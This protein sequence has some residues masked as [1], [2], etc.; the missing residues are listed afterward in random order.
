MGSAQTRPRRKAGKGR[1]AP[2]SAGQDNPWALCQQAFAAY[3]HGRHSRPLRY[4]TI[5]LTT[6]P[7]RC[8][9]AVFL[10][11]QDGLLAKKDEQLPL[12]R[13][14][15]GTLQYIYFVEDFVFVVPVGTEEVVVSD[16][17]CQV[18]AGAV[19]VIK[20]VCMAVR[21][22]IGAVEPF[23]HLFKRAVF[24]RNS[25]IV[26]KADNL[27]DFKH[28]AFAKLLR[29]F[30]CGKWISA[31]A[32]GDKL[33]V[34][35]QFCESSECHAHG[36]DAGADTAVA[37][38]LVADNGAC[39]R[40]HDEPDIGFD[41][42]YFDVGFVSGKYIPFFVGVKVNKG[43]DTDGGGLAVVGDLLMGNADVVQVFECL[44]SFA[45][46]KAEVDMEC[47]AQG[48]DMCVIPAE[49]EGGS[50]LGQGV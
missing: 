2:F 49:F 5:L 4:S 23:D 30:H 43:F 47:E 14:V 37:G 18:I 11:V 29:E 22:F 13:H 40:V 1:S 50:V 31:V 7:L 36:K 21:G 26:G 10:Q 8:Q 20:A 9:T 39:C 3:P 24:R 25:V 19:N 48:H 42:A 28:E 6:A 38:Y 15:I 35:R 17:K 27:C 32:V 41:A 33:K 44:G 16:P 12:A 34:F 46:G 45:K